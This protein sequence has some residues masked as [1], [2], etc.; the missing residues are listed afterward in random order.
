MAQQ[1]SVAAPD[2]D[3][4]HVALEAFRQRE[5]GYRDILEDLPAAIYT[6]DAEGRITYFNKACIEFS[7]RTPSI[8]D[9]LWCVTWKLYT[10]DGAP[11]RHDE[12]PMAIALRERRP[13]RGIEAI[14][15]R[16]DG[17]RVAFLPYPTPIFDEQGELLG[18]VNMLVD[19][20]A[21]KQAREHL[22]LVAREVDHRANN[23][24]A[25]MQGLMLLTKAE[26]V[27]GYK[28]ALAGRFAA[29][30][31]ANSLIASRR[32]TDVNL[33]TLVEEEVQAV[34][35]HQAQVI[36]EPLEISPA[37]AQSLSMVIHELCTNALKYGALTSGEGR[38]VVS[39]KVDGDDRLV[40][41]WREQGPAAAEPSRNGTGS[42]LIAVT[43]RK[44]GATVEREWTA[45]GL[46]FRL[47]CATASL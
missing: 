47:V 28:A 32:W 9:D 7:G 40:F 6:T 35:G 26:T 31:R 16:P 23:L 44:L 19:I 14:A 1:V 38:V 25:V 27:E 15:E 20:T 18:A 42:A 4:L 36:G 45:S 39:W 41:N 12:C 2:V 11:L 17:S 22:A 10:A 43:A 5:I 24:L 33:R 3:I 29:L 37:A 34:C 21:Q 8:G 46:H 30:A 13:V